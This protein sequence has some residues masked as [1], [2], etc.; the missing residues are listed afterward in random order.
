MKA[1][2]RS[3]GKKWIKHFLTKISPLF[4]EPRI[5]NIN[6]ANASNKPSRN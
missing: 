6:S 5:K 1:I 2:G 3:V 4:D